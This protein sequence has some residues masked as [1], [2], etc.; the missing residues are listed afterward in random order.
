[1]SL[2][3]RA[4]QFAPFAALSG[5]DDMI[6]E[7]G[8]LTEDQIELPEHIQEELNNKFMLLKA[9]IEAGYRP[10]IKVTYFVPDKTKDGGSYE[11]YKGE[12]KRVDSTFRTLT[13][14]DK[15]KDLSGKV[16]DIEMITSV[17]SALFD[18]MM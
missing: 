18:E 3:D 10:E 6:A 1:M 11:S 5:Y 2:Y 8:R 16:I 14:Y 15:E 12:V 17:E 7:T 13:F 9:I 4:N